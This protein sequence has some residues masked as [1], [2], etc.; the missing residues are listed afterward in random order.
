MA[1]P[2]A[3]ASVVIDANAVKFVNEMKR[4][5]RSAQR[6]SSKTSGSLSALSGKMKL[7]GAVAVA[8]GAALAFRGAKEGIDRLDKLAKT[9]DKLGVATEALAGIQYGAELAGVGQET[10]NKALVRQQKA[11]SDATNGLKTYTRAFEAIGLKAEDLK[12]LSVDEQFIQIAGALGRVEN[13]TVKT[14]AAYDIFGGR[15]TDLL[16][17]FQDNEEALRA[18]VEEAKAL[19]IAISRVDAAKVEAAKD[20]LTRV[21]FAVDGIVNKA[22]VE[23]APFIVTVAEELVEVAKGFDNAQSSMSA[24]VEGTIV[25]FGLV[26]NAITGAKIALALIESAAY[27]TGEAIYRGLA[28]FGADAFDAIADDMER[29]AGQALDVARRSAEQVRTLGQLFADADAFTQRVAAN[30]ERLA[31][32][33]TKK[34]E[35]PTGETPGTDLAKLKADLDAEAQI[36]MEAARAAAEQEAAIKQEMEALALEGKRLSDQELIALAEETARAKVM[37]EF[38]A[39]Q[40]AKGELNVALTPDQE[41]AQLRAINDAKI[42]EYERLSSAQRSIIDKTLKDKRKEADVTKNINDSILSGSRMF[43]AKNKSLT[44]AAN[45]FANRERVKEAWNSTIVG[46][47]KALEWG[48][49][50]G[51]IFAGIIGAAGAANIASMIGVG[52]GSVGGSI[53]D[54][55]KSAI[56]DTSTPFDDPINAEE[57]RDE[58]RVQIIIQGD[59]NGF[60]DFAQSKI[61]PAIQAAVKDQDVV[62]IDAESRNAAEIID[63]AE[64]NV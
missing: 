45:A 40:A 30:A 4:A 10:L 34:A 22:L 39:E 12:D 2:V 49:P 57:Q 11:I 54:T 43:F 56:A 5:E 23:L 13:Q 26:K 46:M 32:E 9:A 24:V 47:N 16:V 37:A 55:A 38:E 14:A 36:R 59:V 29:R 52:T 58:S 51:P 21:G 42:A 33:A 31:E 63:A 61:I 20:S 28:F 62:L 8:A 41:V 19:G 1:K 60:D 15:A 18:N 17:L 48:W 6:F 25:G 27:K 35:T 44:V 7:L 64:R 53:R 3:A 50:M